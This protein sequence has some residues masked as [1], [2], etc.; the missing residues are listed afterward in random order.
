MDKKNLFHQIGA[1]KYEG[2]TLC[3]RVSEKEREKE[4]KEKKKYTETS[5][6]ISSVNSSTAN[7]NE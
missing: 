1:S 5:R 7:Y 3:D 6:E 2:I 4:K